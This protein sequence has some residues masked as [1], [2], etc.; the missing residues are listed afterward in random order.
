MSPKRKS[1]SSEGIYLKKRKA[2]SME[3]KLDIITRSEKGETPTNIGRVLGLSRTTVSTIICDKKRILEHVKGSPPM[4]STVITKQRSGLI[5]EMER[6]LMLWLEDQR[7]RRIPVTLVL[8]QEKAKSLFETLKREKGEGSKSEKFGASKG[9]FMRFKARANLH[10]LKVQG[11]AASGYEKAPS[12][13]PSTL[14]GIF[15]DGGYSAEQVFNVDETGLFWMPTPGAAADK[16]EVEWTPEEGRTDV[17]C[18]QRWKNHLDP[19]LQNNIWTKEED[20]KLELDT[21]NKK[22]SLKMIFQPP[23]SGPLKRELSQSPIMPLSPHPNP[24]PGFISAA[25]PATDTEQKKF[26]DAALRMI[27]EE[28]LPLSFVEGRGFRSFMNSISPEYNRLS[29]R[30]VSLQLYRDVETTFKPQLIREL[31]TTTKDGEKKI[32]VTFDLW[33]GDDTKL[34]EVPVIVVQL[35]FISETWQ[36][37]RPI[38]AFRHLSCQILSSAVASELERVV[39]SYGVFPHSIG[40]ILINLANEA[41]AANM[42]FGDFEIMCSSTEGE[43]DGDLVMT[44]LSD[45]MPE[46]LSPFPQLEFGT[47]TTCV[48]RGLQQV[49]TEA[50]KNSRVVENLLSQV[51]DVVAFFRSS[52]SWSEVL[53]TEFNVSLCL[54]ST[55][56]RWNNMMLLLRSMAQ[57][58]AWTAVMTALAQARAEATDTDSVLP[59]IMATREQV[60]DILT[61]LQP[62]EEALQV[63][64]GSGATVCLIIPSLIGLDKTLESCVTDYTH[65]REALRTGLHR[66]FQSLI[67]QKDIVLAALLDPRI[68]LKTF[69]DNRAEDQTL[70]L[71]P[72]TKHEACEIMEATLESIAAPAFSSMEENKYQTE[73]QIKMEQNEEIPIT[74]LKEASNNRRD[75]SGVDKVDGNALKRK[76]IFNF[77][78]QPAKM[79]K[80][81]EFEVYLEEPLLEVSSTLLYWKSATRFPLLQSVARKLLA[82][83]ATAGGFDRLFPMAACIMKAR[84]NHLSPQTTE[85]LFLYQNSFKS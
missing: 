8:I 85:R 13:L 9:W 63:L 70:F 44:F 6:L 53:L 75:E 45:Q 60:I 29:Q 33:S 54:P 23:Q 27:A 80:M 34:G 16:S 5:V 35:H 22:D 76:S 41:L 59:L 51:H 37:R 73:H 10:H 81:S 64:Q 39:L 58:A 26:Q 65:F 15:K 71:T 31:E 48:A 28:M 47:E 74:D 14:A 68:K 19:D 21:E 49:I 11:K 72:P 46:T 56:C 67:F 66:H 79:K 7:Q 20:E 78:Q 40:Y 1:D 77:L 84:R 69:P 42:L 24:S 55:Y 50:L 4:K 3:V 52:A 32:H 62:F 38:I 30:A 25:A 17:Q 12:D 36:I 2:I 18:M 82:V 61:L 83:P 43:T 57:E